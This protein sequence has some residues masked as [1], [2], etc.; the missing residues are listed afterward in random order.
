M[1][2]GLKEMRELLS[3]GISGKAIKQKIFHARE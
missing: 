2:S 1:T 3:M